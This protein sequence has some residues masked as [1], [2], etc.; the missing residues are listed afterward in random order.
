[1]KAVALTSKLLFKYILLVVAILMLPLLRDTL[2]CVCVWVCVCGILPVR[3][4][5]STVL[6][7]TYVTL[8]L[9]TTSVRCLLCS[10]KQT[11]ARQCAKLI[12]RE[13]KMS[14]VSRISAHAKV[15]EHSNIGWM[16]VVYEGSCQVAVNDP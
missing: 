8:N 6:T 9:S 15:Y 1:M 12:P 13:W 7:A 16:A 11:A 14:V 5:F 3:H 10:K 2:A 4:N